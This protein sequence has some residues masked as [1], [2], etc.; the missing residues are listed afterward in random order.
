[1]N[2]WMDGWWVNGWMDVQ[3]SDNKQRISE[4][5]AVIEQRRVQRSMASLNDPTAA[6]QPDQQPDPAEETAKAQI[7]QVSFCL[8]TTINTCRTSLVL[9]EQPV[10]FIPIRPTNATIFCLSFCF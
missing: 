7:E 1:M 8:I 10:L 6:F 5:K 3:V 2:E 4:L 9:S